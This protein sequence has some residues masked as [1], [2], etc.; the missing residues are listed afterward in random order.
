MDGNQQNEGMEHKESGEESEVSGSMVD[1]D[2]ERYPDF[3]IEF[4]KIDDIGSDEV[5]D[6]GSDEDE[7]IYGNGSRFEENNNVS[8]GRERR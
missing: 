7:E 3:E 2:D 8:G 5:D 4:G 6:I 1:K